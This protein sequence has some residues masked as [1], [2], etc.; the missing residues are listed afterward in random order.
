MFIELTNKKRKILFPLS[1]ITV[2]Q[3][4]DGKAAV[5]VIGGKELAVE[6]SYEDIIK[7]I[8]LLYKNNGKAWVMMRA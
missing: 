8:N 3:F 5:Q 7:R 1:S 6:E 2:R 4:S